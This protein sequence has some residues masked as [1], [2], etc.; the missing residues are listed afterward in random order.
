MR[1][2]K[3]SLFIIG[4]NVVYGI[5]GAFVAALVLSWFLS[6]AVS[7]ILGILAGL[8]IIYF[9]VISDNITVVL[10]NGEMSVYRIGGRLL[11]RF[12]LD[13][14]SFHA[15]IVTT[16]DMT[17]GDSDCTLTIDCADGG[18]TN[19][20]CSMLGKTTFMELLD[21]LGFNDTQPE[22]LSTTKKDD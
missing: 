10:D 17:G 3:S 18:E 2:Y 16:S 20:D 4:K 8:A 11:H 1:E 22:K 9:A 19:L 7:V 12:R 6:G 15:K 5:A 13:D 14:C 21:A